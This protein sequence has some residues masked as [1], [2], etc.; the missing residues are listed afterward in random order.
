MA[1]KRCSCGKTTLINPNAF[2]NQ[3]RIN[4]SPV[5][6]EDLSIYVELTTHKKARS[7]LLTSKKTGTNTTE[8]E[9]SITVNF[10]EGTNVGGTSGKKY[11]TTSFTEL[12]TS[13][14]NKP[15]KETDELD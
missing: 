12:T 13:L 4:S 6:L 3:D 5:Q 14:D 2:Q 11:L 15:N 10:I 1:N 7:I 8:E 9:G